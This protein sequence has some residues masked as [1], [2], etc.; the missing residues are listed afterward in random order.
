MSIEQRPLPLDVPGGPALSLRR[1]HLRAVGPRAAR[2]DPFDLRHDTPDGSTA[3]RVLW[4]LTNTGGK[5]TIMRLTTSVVVP[6][7]R[8]QMGGANIGEYVDTGDTSHVVLEW[9]IAGGDCF[10]VG[11]VYEWPGRKRPHDAPI[12]ELR[13]YFY[14]FRCN[15]VT[16]DDLPFSVDRRRRTLEEFRNEVREL[17]GAHPAAQFAGTANQGEWAKLLDTRTPLDPELFRYQMR[18]N[19]AESGA[20]A[21]VK[22]LTS[23]ESIVRFFIE[24]LNDDVGIAEFTDTLGDYAR[25]SAKRS[26][27]T[28]EEAFCSSVS[29]ALD[30]LAGAEVV[31]T[32]ARNDNLLAGQRVAEFAGELAARIAAEEVT[33]A[34]LRTQADETATEVA[35]LDNELKRQ[36]DLRQQLLLEDARFDAA[37]AAAHLEHATAHLAAV[38][39]E[40]D[41][42]AATETVSAWRVEQRRVAASERAYAEAEGEL[43]PLRNM[44][45]DSAADLAAKYAALADEAVEAKARAAVALKTAE[46][47]KSRAERRVNAAYRAE[48]EAAARL[49]AID[50]AASDSTATLAR[51]VSEGHASA[52]EMAS[53]ALARWTRDVAAAADVRARL[54]SVRNEAKAQQ[55]TATKAAEAA[56]RDVAR[57]E[58]DHE[59]ARKQLDDYLGDLAAVADDEDVAAVA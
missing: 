22:K 58:A 37:D 42:W 32:T 35:R 31:R 13:R 19:D 38:E 4:S 50:D 14:V 30:P 43:V 41:A 21:L 51:L 36:S 23:A 28:V 20:E 48:L 1:V 29:A 44:T 49:R 39:S 40:R 11:A 7:A 12:S 47:T 24:A 56:R 57:R 3:A 46:D 6:A 54:T 25:H 18:M 52:G 10:V 8:A 27:L 34:D 59:R 9:D 55:A 53:A 17:M 2:L 16:I 45:R 33:L 26:A 15:G 5:T